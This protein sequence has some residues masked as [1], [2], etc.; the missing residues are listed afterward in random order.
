MSRLSV[1]FLAALL[2]AASAVAALAETPSSLAGISLGQPAA[3]AK[4]RVNTAKVR[5]VDGAP[6][7]RR[8][9][10]SGDKH[11]SGGYVLVG[12]CAA[13]GSV[14]RIK[15]R[16]RDTGMDFFRALSG[17]MLS[18]YGDPTEYKGDLEGRV[19]GNK[20][21][22]SDPRLRPVSLIVQHTEGE[23]P[24]L[25]A[26]NTI[27]LTNWGLLEAER[28]CWQERHG[29]ARPARPDKHGRAKDGRDDGYLPR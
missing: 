14:T 27:K 15:M 26:G 28:A 6:W 25:G 16:Y 29:A 3:K 1:V 18:Q 4:G 7:V 8:M 9:P 10:V 23:D 22:F 13:P 17:E 20:W 19:M 21:S 5:D 12:T 24:E 11:F 2:V